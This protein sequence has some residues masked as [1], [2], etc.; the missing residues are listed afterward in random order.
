MTSSIGAEL[1]RLRQEQRLTLKEVS[2]KS[3]LSVSFLSQVE[4]DV[5]TLTFTSVRKIA[6]ALGVSM[7]FFFE[8]KDPSPIKK[9]SFKKQ[10]DQPH[11]SYTNLQGNVEVPKF[12]PARIELKAGE[13]H[14]A[15]YSH[16]GQEFVYV[17]EGEL[18][19]KVE[20]YE[21]VLYPHESLHIDSTKEHIW[22]NE[23]DQP[24]ILLVVSTNE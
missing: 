15:P 16:E 5:S 11:F 20:D 17:L 19:V 4:R 6:E 12:T 8:S 9:K 23:T 14:T 24:V 1:R 2:E 10:D 3:G 13:S 21:D 7:N 22:Y 18:K